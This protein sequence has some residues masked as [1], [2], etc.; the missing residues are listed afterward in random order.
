MSEIENIVKA[1]GVG[2]FGTVEFDEKL[3]VILRTVEMKTPDRGAQV[4]MYF[5]N[6]RQEV[7]TGRRFDIVGSDR[8]LCRTGVAYRVYSHIYVSQDVP[9]AYTVE[10]TEDAKDAFGLLSFS[11]AED[12]Q[13]VFTV[14]AFRAIEIEQWVSI[15]RLMLV[16]LGDETPEETP[17]KTRK[18][19]KKAEPAPEPEVDDAGDSPEESPTE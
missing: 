11:V 4:R 1:S 8:M 16:P 9:V 18:P 7:M 14:F 5:D 6:N 3:R 12:G 2:A 17:K 13:V 19:R 15:A 10:L